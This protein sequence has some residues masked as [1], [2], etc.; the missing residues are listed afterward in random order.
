M[1]ALLLLVSATAT[2]VR[3]ISLIGPDPLHTTAL[4]ASAVGLRTVWIAQNGTCLAQIFTPSEQSRL[5]SQAQLAPGCLGADGRLPALLAVVV[6]P[7]VPLAQETAETAL[8][9]TRAAPVVRIA[10]QSCDRALAGSSNE[11]VVP[12]DVVWRCR[13]ISRHGQFVTG[14]PNFL[15]EG[16]GGA[17][18]H[19][20]QHIHLVRNFS[21]RCSLT[22]TASS[23]HYPSSCHLAPSAQHDIQPCGLA[24]FGRDQGGRA[25]SF[26]PYQIAS[27]TE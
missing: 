4:R 24:A 9:I 6:A 14:V 10:R 8:S 22:T 23:S 2:G 15:V 3:L 5:S 17:R 18:Q 7:F 26:V 20:C 13:P 12:Q 19:F 27:P 21:M 25:C 11:V 1:L 16:R